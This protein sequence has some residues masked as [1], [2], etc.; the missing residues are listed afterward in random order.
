M[1]RS[2]LLTI[3]AVLVIAIVVVCLYLFLPASSSSS[4]SPKTTRYTDSSTGITFEY[5]HDVFATSTRDQSGV[6]EFVAQGMKV[7]PPSLNFAIL[8]RSAST[9]ADVVAYYT[10][11]ELKAIRESGMVIKSKRETIGDVEGNY[12]SGRFGEALI[13]SFVGADKDRGVVLAIEL[14]AP[15][16]YVESVST[17]TVEKMFRDVV[18]SV[19]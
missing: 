14:I 3:V 6:I 7:R 12:V 18:G 5:P 11:G 19:R 17:S 13:Y 2:K 8:S 4:P 16:D 15:V 1:T 9:T 10:E